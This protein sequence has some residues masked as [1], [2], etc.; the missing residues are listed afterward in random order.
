[1]SNYANRGMGLE[2]LI[3]YTNEVYL[4]RHMA[5]VHKRPT[6]VKILQTRGSKV[7]G[8]LEAA[9][10]VDYEGV[11]NGHSLQFEAKSTRD[12]RRLTLD[13][14]HAHQVDHIRE[15]MKQGAVVFVLVE[16]VKHGQ[17]F[18]V[19]GNL[20]VNA[21]DKWKAGGPASLMYDDLS[22]QCTL[23]PKGRGVPLDYLAVVDMVIARKS[24]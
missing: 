12:L 18:Y 20:V 11:Y 15:C 2:A 16:F 17:V 3:T 6:P 13:N 8:Y 7:N 1:M 9:S 19:P 22:V 21:W 24:A 23:I 10:T 14:F 5:V 4:T